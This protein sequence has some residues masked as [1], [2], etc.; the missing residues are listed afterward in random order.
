MTPADVDA[1]QPGGPVVGDV[2][3]FAVL[4]PHHLVDVV[5]DFVEQ[6]R[7]E[8]PGP[9]EPHP[10]KHCWHTAGHPIHEQLDPRWLA[11]P[12]LVVES[13]C[14][15]MPYL[16][17]EAPRPACFRD[18]VRAAELVSTICRSPTI[19][20]DGTDAN[21]SSTTRRASIGGL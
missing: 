8:D 13:G 11:V 3:T 9:Q 15:D 19:C 4:R 20:S 17:P 18:P 7:P 12:R 14:I 6:H 21:R 2:L 1:R 16:A 10:Q 5:A